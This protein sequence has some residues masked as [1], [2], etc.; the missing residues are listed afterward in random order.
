MLL[1]RISREMQVKITAGYHLTPI[2]MAAIRSEKEVA[3]VSE[4][5]K[6]RESLCTV[7]ENVKWCQHYRQ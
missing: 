4:D 1:S 7:D 2:G 3:S 6:K 5:L